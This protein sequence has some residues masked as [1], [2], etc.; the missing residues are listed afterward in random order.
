MEELFASGFNAWG[1]L[2]FEDQNSWNENVDDVREF[3]CVL[4]GEAIAHVQAFLSHTSRTFLS[5]SVMDGYEWGLIRSYIVSEMQ[6]HNENCWL[7]PKGALRHAA[8]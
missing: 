1:Q 4:R 5:R 3:K 2:D 6:R 7:L 8:P